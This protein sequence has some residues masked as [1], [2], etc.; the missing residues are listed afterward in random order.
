MTAQFTLSAFGDEIDDAVETQL[1]VLRDLDIG[2]LELRSAWGTNVLVL[3][4][5]Q[6]NRLNDL[7]E[8]AFDSGELHWKSD[9]QI[10]CR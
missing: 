2:Y 3:S 9:R 7:C 5:A 8:S 4:D 6:V 10:A 1:K